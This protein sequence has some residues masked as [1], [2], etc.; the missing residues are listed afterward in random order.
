LN[1]NRFSL[2]DPQ[3]TANWTVSH[4]RLSADAMSALQ[5]ALAD[6]GVF[7]S[8]PAGLRMASEQF[9][10][11]SAACRDGQFHFNAW[12]YP[13]DRFA[14]LRFPAVLLDHDQT[15]VAPNPPRQVVPLEAG[16]VRTR[17]GDPTIRFLLQVG[18]NGLVT[19]PAF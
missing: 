5:A 18:A 15:G 1:L 7:S 17:D 6:S 11:T 12:L 13:S 14:Q 3:A 19:G 9:Y 2:D 10:W 4:A 16:R 8:G